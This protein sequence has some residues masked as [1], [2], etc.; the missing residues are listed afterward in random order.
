MRKG[1]K[2]GTGHEQ[3]DCSTCQ[4][5]AAEPVR[6]TMHG[7]A[8]K[9]RVLILD[10]DPVVRDVVTDMLRSIGYSAYAAETIDE[11][12]DCYHQAKRC[13]FPFQTV[14]M[15]LMVSRPAGGRETS[16]RFPDNDRQVRTVAMSGVNVER[17]VSECRQ[18]GIRVALWK[19]FT[20][21]ELEQA[22]APGS[23]RSEI[24]AALRAAMREERT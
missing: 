19:P 21:H 7:Q 4:Q 24:S 8:H 10:N 6:K 23:G 5:R 14:L 1:P 12:A 2:I 13:G 11:A 9:G 17:T 16:V 20:L 22:L 18:R 15:D 3:A